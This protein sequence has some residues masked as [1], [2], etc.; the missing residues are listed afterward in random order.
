MPQNAVLCSPTLHGSDVMTDFP[1]YRVRYV[2]K[3]GKENVITIGAKSDDDCVN[4]ILAIAGVR[5]LEDMEEMEI[6]AHEGNIVRLWHP[7]AGVRMHMAKEKPKDTEP[8]ASPKEEAPAKDKPAAP[9]EA[10]ADVVTV[11]GSWPPT[12]THATLVWK[13]KTFHLANKQEG[14]KLCLTS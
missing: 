4:A 6:H 1:K 12:R 14:N 8:A 7:I 2:T 13:L 11:T 9:A 10:S 3:R 5:S